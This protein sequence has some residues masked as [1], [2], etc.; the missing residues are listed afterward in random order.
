MASIVIQFLNG[1]AIA[2]TLFL[3]AVGL[4]LIFGVTRIVNFAHGSLY[5]LGIY[6]AYSFIATMDA[7]IAGFWSGVVAAALAVGILGALVEMLLLRRIYQAPELFQLLATFAL[8]LVIKDFALWTWG[9]E[10][11][12]GPRAPGLK[13]VGRHLRRSFSGV[14]PRV[15]RDRAARASCALCSRSI[16]L[17]GARSFARP[18]KTARWSARSA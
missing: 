9:A 14:R 5:M 13:G 18:R 16:A 10:D 8:T 6:I 7:G 4:S 1:L 17:A 2:S 12:L 15:D 3:V 11:L